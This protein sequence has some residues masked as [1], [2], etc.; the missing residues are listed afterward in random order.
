RR[1]K[2]ESHPDASV[3]LRMRARKVESVAFMV[4]GPLDADLELELTTRGTPTR[5]LKTT[6]YERYRLLGSRVASG[7][8]VFETVRVRL[9]LSCTLDATTPLTVKGG[10]HAHEPLT[11]GARYANGA[12]TN[13]S[14][15]VAPEMKPI[16]P[17][18]EVQR[19]GAFSCALTPSFQL[20]VY[21]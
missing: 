12:W 13:L 5:D 10:V 20:F 7:V 15:I 6:L 21:N 1:G 19:P 2:V 11:I 8:P 9:E 4:Q 14:E 18:L 16:A 3:A 17:V